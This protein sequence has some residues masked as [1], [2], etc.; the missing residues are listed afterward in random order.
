MTTGTTTSHPGAAHERLLDGTPVTSRRL[1]ASGMSTN[2]LECGQ[3]DPVVLLHGPGEFAAGW[4]EVMTAL[5]RTHRTVAPDLPGHGASDAS[6]E[7][8][9]VRVIDWLDDVIGGTCDARPAVV[10]RVGGGAIAAR[11]AAERAGRLSRL[12]LVDTL[13][14]AP[15]EPAPSFGEA[16][17]RFMVE[18]NQA[19]YDGLMQYCMHDIEAV[20]VRLGDRWDAFADYA[21]GRAAT[22]TTRDAG[23]ALMAAFAGEIPEHELAAITAPTTLIWGR[24]DLATPLR[25]AES[26]SETFGWPLHVIEHAAD[27]P[28]LDQ[29]AAFVEVLSA[30]LNER[31]QRVDAAEERR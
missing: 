5:A 3:G 28:A 19:T 26:A 25:V 2:V 24:H 13:G 20:R 17:Q 22:A 8:D 29:P 1:D 18:P 27:D 11:F 10:G 30:V 21:V 6:S 23:G 9:K 7:L 16:L 4:L 15:F 12:V 31:A 14:L